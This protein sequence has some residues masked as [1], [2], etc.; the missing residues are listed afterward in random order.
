M[1]CCQNISLSSQSNHQYLFGN[2]ELSLNENAS[3]I[4]S[5][6]L[7]E[8]IGVYFYNYWTGDK[9]LLISFS[10]IRSIITNFASQKVKNLFCLVTVKG[11]TLNFKYFSTCFCFKSVSC[12]Y[13]ITHWTSTLPTWFKAPCI[14]HVWQR[15]SH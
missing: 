8:K 2:L 3:T 6:F 5:V 15:C 1:C 11:P 9:T 7:F 13:M 10:N 4:H 12:K 14:A